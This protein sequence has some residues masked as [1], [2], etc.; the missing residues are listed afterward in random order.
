MTWLGRGG[1]H[2]AT[3]TSPLWS[4]PR[5]VAATSEQR[6]SFAGTLRFMS[7]VIRKLGL[8]RLGWDAWERGLPWA[9]ARWDGRVVSDWG[10]Q[11]P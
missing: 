5:L 6:S 9:T 2:G 7:S 1:L 11:R 10:D 8:G 4:L 3:S